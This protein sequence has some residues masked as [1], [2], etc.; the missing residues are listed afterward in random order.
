VSKPW[1]DYASDEGPWNDYKAQDTV[2][3]KAGRGIM[4]VPRQIGLAGRYI[5]E[6]PAM[7]ADLLTEPIRNFVVNPIIN[8]FGGT[9][10][11][12]TYQA[13]SSVADT[14]GLPAPENANE[15]VV[16]DASRLLA[17]AGPMIGGARAAAP[18]ATGA[19]KAVMEGVANSPAIQASSL[20]GAGAAGGSVREAGGGPSAQF[21]ASLAGGIAAPL[22]V[23]GVTRTVESAAQGLQRLFG[24]K[25]IEA[26]LKVELDRAGVDWNALSRQAQVSL[27][28][29]ARKAIYN[30]EPLSQDALRRLSDFRNIGAKPMVGSVTQDPS[31]LTAER[32]LAKQQA[33]TTSTLGVNLPEVQNQNAQRVLTTLES[34]ADS[35]LDAYGTGQG[36][37]KSVEATDAAMTA[38]KRALYANAETQAGR[39]I[40]LDREGFVNQAFDNLAKSNRG[41]WLPGEVRSLLNDISAGKAPFTVDTI[42]MLKTLLA[43]ESRATANGNVRHALS[44]VRSAL[45]NIDV[46]PQHRPTGSTLPITQETASRLRAADAVTPRMSTEA[47]AALDRARASAKSQF[48]WQKSAPFIEDALGGAAPDKFVQKHVINAPVEDLAKV[49]QFVQNDPTLKE[50][51]RKQL[52]EYVMARGK[53]DSD[54]VKFSSAGMFDAFN[55][56][57]KRKWAMFFTPKEVGQI[58]SAI[59]VGRYMQSQPIG[60]AVNNSNTAAM[61]WGRLSDLLAK[62]QALPVVGPLI[63]SPVRNVTLSLQGQSLANV[64]G[65]LIPAAPRQPFPVNPLLLA[66]GAPRSDQ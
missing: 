26:V 16:A 14:M 43:Q 17:G 6:G 2:S 66:A 3:V 47:L 51:V 57:G 40:P 50:A 56:I 28:A 48:D 27:A 18:F 53:A 15:R 61:I 20:V 32:N 44:D 24:T 42:D 37:I 63:A 64:G 10:I 46:A 55:A 11:K 65:A 25:N 1:E 9:P 5:M 54:I 21:G 19:T 29:D 23:G 7:T 30:G 8:A 36:I 22:A 39:T 4:E 13:A 60:S 38:E 52:I 62:G 12:S 41:G 58:R 59:N 31:L 45:E 35:P 34:S 33:N 49:Q